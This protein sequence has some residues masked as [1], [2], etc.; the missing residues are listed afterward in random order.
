M[1]PDA[2]PIHVRRLVAADRAAWDRLW[3]G[4]LKFYEEDVDGRVTEVVFGR[5]VD[6][7]WSQQRGYVAE[8]EGEV[9]GIAHVG[10]QPSTWSTALDCYLE[11][12]YVAPSARGDGAGRALIEHLVAEGREVGWRKV[13]WLTD[14]DNATARR[15]Y[16]E[17]GELADQVRYT[18]DVTDSPTP[19]LGHR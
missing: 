9:V 1:T 16:D 3:A 12:L 11:D 10:L 7:G 2:P 4:Y 14:T 13:H 5:L 18:I 6:P 8:V 17:V 19:L 15:L